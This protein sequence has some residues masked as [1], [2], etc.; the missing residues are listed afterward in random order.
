MA[1]LTREKVALEKDKT[2]IT[3][4]LGVC[5][6]KLIAEETKAQQLRTELGQLQG[7]ILISCIV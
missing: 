6:Q 5:Q 3:N 1:Q 4:Q 2:T 7:I